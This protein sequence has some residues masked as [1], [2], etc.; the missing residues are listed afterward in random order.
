[1]QRCRRA[2]GRVKDGASE[3]MKMRHTVTVK[4]SRLE[5]SKQ[6]VLEC[7]W[8]EIRLTG[9]TVKNEVI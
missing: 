3:T 4:M 7:S 6:Q 5:I 9:L 8:R 1:M 2:K